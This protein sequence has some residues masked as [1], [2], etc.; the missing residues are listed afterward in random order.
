MRGLL[1]EYGV[2]IPRSPER[3]LTALPA[4]IEDARLP[5]L[6]HALLLEVREQLS[7]LHARL[8]KCDAHI[9]SHAKHSTAS[10]LA[11][12]VPDARVFKTVDDLVPGWG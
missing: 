4:L 5:D 6:I 8:A 3:L 10:A 11:A 2:V 12:T 7:A 1:A 9:A